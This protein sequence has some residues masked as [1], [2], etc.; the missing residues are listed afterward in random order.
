M[1]P[2]TSEADIS[3][4]AA[5]NVAL[6]SDAY[7][8]AFPLVVSD[9]TRATQT[10]VATPTEREGCAPLG[11]VF[12]GDRRPD[13]DNHLVVSPNCDTLYTTGWIDVGAEPW[14][15]SMPEHGDRYLLMQVLGGWTDVIGSFGTRTEG[16]RAFDVAIATER[17]KG[18]LPDG[19]SLLRSPSDAVWLIGR[20][21]YTGPDDVEE[22]IA[23]GKNIGL[24]P[25]STW[26]RGYVAPARAEVDRSVNLARSPLANVLAM[27]PIEFFERFQSLLASTRPASAD[28]SATKRFEALGIHANGTL[29][30]NALRA[31]GNALD[32]GVED[33]KERIRR[34]AASIGTVSNGWRFVPEPGR[35]GTRYLDRAA[36]AW[37]ALGANLPE[38]AIYPT[39]RVDEA[40]EPLDG[41]QQYVL[42]FEKGAQPPAK[43]FWSVTL[44]D[45]AQHFAK[46][47][48][49][50][51]SLGD[52]SDLAYGPDGA[53]EIFLGA[54]P[55]ADENARGNWLP[56][57]RAPFNLILR[58][59]GP[60]RAVLDGTW[61]PPAVHRVKQS[62]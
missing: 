24:A 13:P 52:R 29:D 50:R 54:E 22:A 21:A 47:D 5:Q 25:L 40:G 51:Y 16:G 6:V 1:R 61:K 56:A 34:A 38:D 23:I 4:R 19:V 49:E 55:P 7:V 36:V 14:I 10:A 41:S 33:A 31:M 35:F 48:L 26:R 39:T 27:T 45:D 62:S 30:R 17:W 58:I 12:R 43:F 44:Y 3:S 59:Y 2:D 18:R 15:L 20:T 42:R 46:N 28:A 57:P 32:R 60:E 8:F 9:S 53:L 37:F 11:Q